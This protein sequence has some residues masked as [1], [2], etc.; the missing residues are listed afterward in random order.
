[1]ER[2]D[3]IERIM[4]SSVP[5]RQ[6]GLNGYPK[7][8]ASGVIVNYCSKR[9]F[10]TVFHAVKDFDNWNIEVKSDFKN[11]TKL[12]GLGLMGRTVVANLDNDEIKDIDFAYQTISEDFKSYYQFVENDTL[13]E[14]ERIILDLNFDVAV[15]EENKYGFFGQA[16]FDKQGK[17]IQII[18]KLVLDLKFIKE[19]DLYYIFKLPTKHPGHKYFKGTSGAPILNEEGELVSLVCGGDVDNDHIIGLNLKKMKSIIE[20][21]CKDE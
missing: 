8:N 17:I 1:V 5:I 16:E 14:A 21:Q 11:G 18:S 12:Q 7:S 6:I 15:N 4:L 2:D 3:L 20:I 19:E 9:L 10:F 13:Y